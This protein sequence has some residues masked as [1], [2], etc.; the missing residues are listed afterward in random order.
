MVNNLII[1]VE[2]LTRR[3]YNIEFVIDKYHEW[4]NEKEKFEKY[5]HE[6]TKELI[7]DRTGDSVSDK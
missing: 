5:I 3:V 6:K 2:N 4:K 7:K 1:N